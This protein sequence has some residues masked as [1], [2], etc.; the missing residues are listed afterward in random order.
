MHEQRKSTRRGLLL[1]SF[2]AYDPPLASTKSWLIHAGYIILGFQYPRF[3]WNSSAYIIWYHEDFFMLRSKHWLQFLGIYSSAD[4]LERTMIQDISR[5]LL[6][7]IPGRGCI[8][9]PSPWLLEIMRTMLLQPRDSRRVVSGS[10]YDC[11]VHVH[12]PL[13]VAIATPCIDSLLE[14][15]FLDCLSI[16]RHAGKVPRPC[17]YN[18]LISL[19]LKVTRS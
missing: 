18:S 15:R 4:S 12:H 7:V 10:A 6:A 19:S 9:S 2:I 14:S 8:R 1:T 5:S 16:D 13:W 17:I 3:F 11:H